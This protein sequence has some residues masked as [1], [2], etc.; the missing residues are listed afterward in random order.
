MASK[1]IVVGAHYGLLDWM[2][3]RVTAVILAV[4]TV[5]LGVSLLALPELNHTSWKALFSGTFMRV[6]SLLALL[7]L[8]WHAWIGVR[9]IFMD[10][11]KPTALRLTLQVLTIVLLVG[12]AIWAINIL[13]SK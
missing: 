12:Y 4:Y 10:Y 3:Q 2:A 1:K 6:L 11:I 9:D 13:W 7:A 8:F 5:V